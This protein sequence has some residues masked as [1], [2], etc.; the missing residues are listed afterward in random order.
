MLSP[1]LDKAIDACVRDMAKAVR[2]GGNLDTNSL[3]AALEALGAVHET[4][5]GEVAERFKLDWLREQVLARFVARLEMRLQQ[6]LGP[7]PV[8]SSELRTMFD[9]VLA[10]G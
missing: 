7:D 3:W 2:D 4:A 8:I 1:K 10:G 6:R 9:D 5:D